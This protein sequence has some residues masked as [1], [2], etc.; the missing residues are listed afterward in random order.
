[1]KILE[2]LTPHLVIDDETNTFR[3]DEDE[4]RKKFTILLEK[5]VGCIHRD[6]HSFPI[7]FDYV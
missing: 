7:D 4:K 6:L 1:M 3:G 2:P 5:T